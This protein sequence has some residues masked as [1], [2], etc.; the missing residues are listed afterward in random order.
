MTD[1]A[2][3]DFPPSLLRGGAFLLRHEDSASIFTPEAF[4]EE[5][6]LIAA[7]CQGFLKEE[8]LTRLAEVEASP[9]W[10]PELL[11]K[12]GAL[13]LLGVS[14]PT[15]YGGLGMDFLDSLLVV[16]AMG[17][18][19]SF[20]TTYGAHTGIGTL[21]IVC[22][23]TEA[24]KSKYLPDIVSAKKKTCYCLTEPEAGSD[25]NA[26]KTT[27]IPT[28]DG[29]HYVLNGQKMWISNAGFADLFIVFAKVAQ[30]KKLSAFIVERAFGGITLGE[31]EKKMGLHGS[32]TR[33]VFFTDCKVPAGSMLSERGTGFKIALNI[34][35]AGRIKLAAFTLSGTKQAIGR[36]VGYARERKQ[37][38]KA[39]A[40]FG[41]IQSKLSEMVWRTYACESATYRAG[42]TISRAISFYKEKGLPDGVAKMKG[43]EEYAAECAF[44][45]VY[46]S[47]TLGVVVDHAVQ[48]YGGMGFSEEMPIAGAYRDA[49]VSRIYEGSNEINRLLVVSMLVKRGM[50]GML[51]LKEGIEA[52]VRELTA[53]PVMG[54]PSGSSG[55]FA[56]EEA[57]LAQL[58]K[59]VLILSGKVME[60]YAERVEEH[61]ELLLHIAD[62]IAEIYV[63]E[64][65]LLRVKKQAEC[66]D[67]SLGVLRAML[68]CCQVCA[69]ETARRAGNEIIPFLRLPTEEENILFMFL[70]RCTRQ[71][72]VD[73]I[74]LGRT[75]AAAALEKQGYPFPSY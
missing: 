34:L 52:A 11:V 17:A 36:A 38:G 19:A 21:P 49:R 5:Q 12:A 33:Q 44:L 64:S 65:T 56:H 45:K 48:I 66:A 42:G 10:A 74:R 15:E 58:K 1:L 60:K 26:G 28:A 43:T 16:E 8:V 3:H 13:G 23:G 73:V 24:Q 35:N 47:E 25:A 32:S 75:I 7:T 31:E 9:Q 41:A 53:P 70:R 22:Y 37:F 30:D 61:Q 2:P 39:I 67:P 20:S 68:T 59:L 69:V 40:S 18:N 57:L 29:K 55:E 63:S 72:H 6:R 51:P 54:D 27:A 50:E 14:V 71:K 62:V 4:S 46:A